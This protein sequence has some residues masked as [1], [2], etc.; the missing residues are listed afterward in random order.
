MTILDKI[1]MYLKESAGNPKAGEKW[2]W[3]D[4]REFKVIN[5]GSGIGASGK[6][7]EVMFKG[8]KTTRD[9]KITDFFKRGKGATLLEA[10]KG[11]KMDFECMECGKKFSK[12]VK[13]T[14][15]DVR[16]PKCRGVDVEPS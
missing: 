16:C 3:Q 9:I 12:S 15:A 5:V 4:G 2:K 14:F 1:D 11:V 8:E 6:Y 13:S 10:K 7:I